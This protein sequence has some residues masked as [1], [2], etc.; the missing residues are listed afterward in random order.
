MNQKTFGWLL[1]ALVVS[2]VGGTWLVLCLVA[3]FIAVW[4]TEHPR[5][6]Q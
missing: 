5:S 1:G 3:F 4:F 6:F 2:L